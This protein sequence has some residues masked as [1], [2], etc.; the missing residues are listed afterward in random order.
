MQEFDP[1][2]IREGWR[3]TSQEL[4]E[5]LRGQTLC[6]IATIDA[7]GKPSIA[8]VAFSVSEAGEFIIGTSEA[9]RKA[10]NIA[11]NSAVALETTDENKRYTVQAE[12]LARAVEAEEFNEVYADEHYNQ[13]P[14]SRPFK[15]QPGQ[16]HFV[17]TPTW[18]RFSDCSVQP[19][20]LTEY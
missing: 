9:S 3:P 1:N 7:E 11:A 10:E 14:A 17:I 18:L 16:V 4:G 6:S 2:N 12:G 8:R 19:W 15:D 5:F 20:Q 13:L